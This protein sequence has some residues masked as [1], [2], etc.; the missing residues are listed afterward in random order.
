MNKSYLNCIIIDKNLNSQLC[1]IT[2][3]ILF[4]DD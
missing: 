2:A 3:S 4:S 1:R